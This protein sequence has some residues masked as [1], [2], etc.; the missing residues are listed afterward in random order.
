MNDLAFAPYAVVVGDAP[1][2]RYQSAG[3]LRQALRWTREELEAGAP[4]VTI[5]A[6]D[7]AL[8]LRKLA[9][10]GG[11]LP[12]G[13]TVALSRHEVQFTREHL[14]LVAALERRVPTPY[15]RTLPDVGAPT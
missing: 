5:K 14:A 10:L 2:L 15:R 6:N 8:L 7:L 1:P 11:A 12:N 13:E 9:A 3:S 4:A